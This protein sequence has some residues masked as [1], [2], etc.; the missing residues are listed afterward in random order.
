MRGAGVK[1]LVEDGS[2]GVYVSLMELYALA[3]DREN[4]HH[5]GRGRRRATIM[6]GE[7]QGAL[8]SL[9]KMKV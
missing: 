6:Q 1:E 2:G 9:A 3:I 4:R 5:E 7:V 8:W